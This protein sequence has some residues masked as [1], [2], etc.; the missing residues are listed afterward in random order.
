MEKLKTVIYQ[1]TY[2]RVP[3]TF[4]DYLVHHGGKYV[5]KSKLKAVKNYAAKVEKSIE[6]LSKLKREEYV[7]VKSANG[8]TTA[9]VTPGFNAQKVWDNK[10]HYA[11]NRGVGYFLTVNKAQYEKHTNQSPTQEEE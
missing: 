10:T 9:F 7:F 4:A 5:S 2:R 6:I 3:A 11:T 1:G 8:S